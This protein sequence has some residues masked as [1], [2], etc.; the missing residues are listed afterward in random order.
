MVP[1]VDRTI[2]L[3][4]I[5]HQV[6]D[7]I[8]AEH[9]AAESRLGGT[10]SRRCCQ[11]LRGI[12]IRQYDNHLLG[13]LLSQQVVKNIV[14]AAYLIIDF[15][16][17]GGTAD[18]IEYRIFLLIVLQI[19]GRQIDNG[20][21]GAAE[22]LRVVVNILHPSVRHILNVMDTFAVGNLQQAVLEALIG[23]ILVIEGVHDAHPVNHKTVGIHV[24]GG[25]T[26]GCRP[27]TVGTMCHQITSGELHIHLDF[28]CILIPIAECH[29]TIGIADG[30]LLAWGLLSPAA[31]CK[32]KGYG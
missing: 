22:A 25:W 16:G 13:S 4:N 7:K 21:I 17:I 14:H 28:L 23:E 27:Y 20:I 19:V 5:W 26:K 10:T 11:Q 8:L 3:L 15:F 12:A 24:G 29:C 2:I 31:Y 1:I 30:R 6:I 18:Q 9:I 32:C